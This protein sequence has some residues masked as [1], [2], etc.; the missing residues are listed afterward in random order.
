MQSALFRK[1]Q[2]PDFAAISK[3]SASHQAIIN[4]KTV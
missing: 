2:K 1:P 3:S 4:Q